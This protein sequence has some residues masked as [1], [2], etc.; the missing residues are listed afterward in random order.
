MSLTVPATLSPSK[1][2]AFK[3]CPLAFRFSAI[4]RLPQ[5][6]S[7]AAT[8]GTLVHRALELLFWELPAG[9][10]HLSDGLD[11][12]ERAWREIQDDPEYF[13]L[14]LGAAQAEA[15]RAEAETLVQKYFD[16][17]DPNQVNVIGTELMLE[18]QVGDMR[19]RGIIDRL[20]VDADGEFVVTDYKTG[21]VPGPAQEQARLA[22]VHFYAYLCEAVFGRRPSQVQLIYLSQPSVITTVPTEQ[23][24]RGL[25]QRTNA[26]WSA[27]RKA[28]EEEDFRPKPSGLC[29]FCSYKAYCPAFGG[30]PAQATLLRSE[31]PA[32]AISA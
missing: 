17:E 8:K 27:V 9:R 28:C 15:F 21:R 13:D 7:V 26:V 12:L 18:A 19:L 3:E 31:N 10:R 32:L 20:D 4:D 24:L 1:V 5:A 29:S 23:S 11:R 14:Q 2:S 25:R 6:P 22:G 30:D 16:I